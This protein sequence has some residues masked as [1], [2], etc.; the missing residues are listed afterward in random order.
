MFIIIIKLYRFD[1]KHVSIKIFQNNI[2]FRIF[3]Q[4]LT[5]VAIF[6]KLKNLKITQVIQSKIVLFQKNVNLIVIFFFNCT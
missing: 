1:G 6:K 5:V 3:K 4:E 2:S